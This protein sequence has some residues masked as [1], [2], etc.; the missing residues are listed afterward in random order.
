MA[1]AYRC[2]TATGVGV[3]VWDG[4]ITVD[5]ARQHVQ[6]LAADPHW[7]ASRRLV[8]DLT[9][10]SAESRPTAEAIAQL[11]DVFLQQLAYRVGDVKWSVIADH[12]FDEALGFGGRIRHEVRRMIVFNNLASACV[13]LGLDHNEVRPAIDELRRQLR[14]ES[15]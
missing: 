12:T 13:W 7:S 2:D 5:Q 14:N 15:R 9:G 4:D 11:A 1:I 8:T 10:I 3:E 6:T